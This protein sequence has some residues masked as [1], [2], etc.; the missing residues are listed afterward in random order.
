MFIEKSG[1]KT[2][3]LH[4]FGVFG[5]A[6]AGFQQCGNVFPLTPKGGIKLLADGVFAACHNYGII[7]EVIGKGALL[8]VNK[9]NIFIGKIKGKPAFDSG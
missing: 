2:L 7:S 4:E 9:S 3:V 1:K 5:V 8:W 6:S